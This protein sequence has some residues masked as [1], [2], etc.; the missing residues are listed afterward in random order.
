MSTNKT[1]NYQLNQWVKS[2]QV[3]MEEFNTDNAKIDAALASKAST[4]A[5]N[6]LQSVVNGKASASALSSLSATVS[7]HSTSMAKKGNCILYTSTYT[8]S[9]ERER[10]STFS[11]SFPHKPIVLLIAHQSSDGITI[12]VQG[13]V[14]GPTLKI[15]QTHAN[16]FTWSGN[17]VSI[18]T[19]FANNKGDTYYVAALLDAEQ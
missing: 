1:Q 15:A 13:G 7:G 17:S 18:R 8:G 6:S 10:L 3:K 14:Q 9:G 4:S 12:G 5:L 2:D 11:L 19:Y 16:D